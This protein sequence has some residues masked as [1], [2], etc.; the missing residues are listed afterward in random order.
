MKTIRLTLGILLLISMFLLPNAES[1]DYTKLGL[2]MGA[3]MRIGKGRVYGHVTFSPDS[4]LLAVPTT[5]GIWIYDG[6]TGKERNLLVSESGIANSVAFSPDGKTLASGHY[7][8][9]HFWDVNTGKLKQTLT[10]HQGAVSSIAFSP[11]GKTLATASWSDE[12]VKLWDV[13]SGKQILNFVAYDDYVE[14]LAMSP[15]G[16]TIATSGNDDYNDNDTIKLWDLNTGRLKATLTTEGFEQIRHIAYSP[17]GN[18]IASGNGW[19][20]FS[21]VRLW[22]VGTKTLKDTLLG[23]GDTVL[24]VAFSLDGKTIASGSRDNTVV[25]W[26][27]D[28]NYKNT[29][30]NHT[31][32]VVSTAFS[33]DGKTIASA[34]WDSTI[35]L[36][37]A[38][39]L[40][41][42]VTINGH[43]SGLNS[44]NFSPDGKTIVSGGDDRIVRL[45]D[46]TTGENIRS[47]TG[48][49]G[50]VLS[51]A[52]SPDGRTIA[53]ASG[54]NYESDWYGKDPT[55]RLWDTESGIQKQILFGD[56]TATYHVAYSPDGQVLV[57][58]GSDKKAIFWDTATGN[59]LWT[60]AGKARTD[61]D[62]DLNGEGVG[63]VLF[64]P[65]GMMVSSGEKSETSVW[66][67]SSRQLIATFSSTSNKTSASAFSPDGKT[68]A[69]LYANGEIHLYNIAT[70]TR[71][72]IIS[73]HTSDLSLIAF[74]PNGKTLATA[75]FHEESIVRFWDP[76]SG[77]LQSAILGH[78]NGVA[79]IAFNP[80]GTALATA[81]WGGTILLW[82]VPSVINLLLHES[83]ITGDGILS[84]H[85]LM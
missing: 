27:I 65:D 69:T 14:S 12:T 85:D 1:Q 30:P 48:H 32:T 20:N 50:V 31:D 54:P 23:H 74:S 71:K 36:W 2:P 80:D 59:P 29:L 37:D 4:S 73:G 43:T 45:W 24:T 55:V 41:P 66:D 34:S 15:D 64:S 38:K 77:E 18:T 76:D 47:Y 39:N 57:S 56:R 81:S 58:C 22:D 3:K 63:R 28:G 11:D 79:S 44:I 26:D 33:P 9:F 46:I 42:R 35:I 49:T 16:K 7:Q 78:Q 68:I 67:T 52:F 6:F 75:D 53:S 61:G 5:V 8:K 40:Q 25:L 83:D 70:R 13:A 21:F 84:I 72:T 62:I 82:D 19:S 51:V 10:G 17:D 60:I